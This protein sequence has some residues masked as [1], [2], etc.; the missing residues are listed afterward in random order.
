MNPVAEFAAFFKN[1][2]P[3]MYAILATGLLV[4]ALSLE[5]FWVIQRAAALNSVKLSKD[6]LRLVRGGDKRAAVQLC[7]KVEAPVTR[8]AKAILQRE[9]AAP[10]TEE[11]LQ[12]AADGAATVVLPPLGRRLSYLNMLA[13]TATLLGLLGTIFGLTTAFNAVDTA[14]AS[15]RSAFLAAGISQALNTTAF[16]LIIAVPALLIHGFLVSKVEGIVD[17]VDALS[18]RLISLLTGGA[19][20]L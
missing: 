17:S 13:N 10:A 11:T 14:D 2:G 20:E 1:G 8:V 19:E 3:F 18:V 15:Q 4:L 9:G 6:L 16:G 12:A 5:R 7:Q